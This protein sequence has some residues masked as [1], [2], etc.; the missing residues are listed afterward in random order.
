M[1]ANANRI[2]RKKSSRSSAIRTH[3]FDIVAIVE[4]KRSEHPPK[5]EG[6]TWN[7]KKGRKGGGI[8]FAYK[9]EL[10]NII[11]EKEGEDDTELL[12]MEIKTGKTQTFIGTYYRHQEGT[13]NQTQK[14]IGKMRSQIHRLQHEGEIITLGDF[15]AKIQINKEHEKQ[16]TS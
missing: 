14:E 13:P 6:Y 1:Y 5:I 12:W 8:A 7:I 4:K 3:N 9:E 16:E 2:T 10:D 11:T 15:N